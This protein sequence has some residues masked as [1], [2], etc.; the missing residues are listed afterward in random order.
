MEL[1]KAVVLSGS[2]DFFKIN[3]VRVRWCMVFRRKLSLTKGLSLGMWLIAWGRVLW[4]CFTTVSMLCL[5][6][7]LPHM[8]ASLVPV[9]GDLA[10]RVALGWWALY[11]L[12]PS[13]PSPPAEPDWLQKSK[14]RG[15][16]QLCS[17]PPTYLF[18]ITEIIC[19]SWMKFLKKCMEKNYFLIL[20]FMFV[21]VL[22]PFSLAWMFMW[23]W[24]WI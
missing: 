23:D 19:S 9:Q 18:L 3:T 15:Y 13:C 4:K 2:C 21:H 24:L 11:S 10:R 20:P 8:H 16:F 17:P 6:M 7:F 22:K 12:F 5:L 1:L 14:P